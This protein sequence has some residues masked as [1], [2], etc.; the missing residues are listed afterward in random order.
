MYR[1]LTSTRQGQVVSFLIVLILIASFM[2]SSR[3]PTATVDAPKP[4]V[5]APPPETPLCEPAADA[6]VQEDLWQELWQ[7]LQKFL[8]TSEQA[9]NFKKFV[10][11]LGG[12]CKTKAAKAQDE[13]SEI[14]EPAVKELIDSLYS[15]NKDTGIRAGWALIRIGEPSVQPLLDELAVCE[16]KDAQYLIKRILKHIGPAIGPLKKLRGNARLQEA[17]KEILEEIQKDK[18]SESDAVSSCAPDAAEAVEAYEQV[19]VDY[20]EAAKN[21]RKQKANLQTAARIALR[22]HSEN[23]VKRA[24]ELREKIEEGEK[25]LAELDEQVKSAKDKIPE[26]TS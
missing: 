11:E 1:W 13:L 20:R 7:K 9:P 21:L 12:A 5:P 23:W 19:L 17:A 22:K 26:P 10:S 15:A 2:R 8:P 18:L 16:K 4:P 25:S 24:L 14:G 6:P 3:A